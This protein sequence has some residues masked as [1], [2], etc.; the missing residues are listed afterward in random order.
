MAQGT[1]RGVPID[2]DPTLAPN[3]DILVPSQSAVRGYAVPQTRTLTING[4]TYDLSADRT[5]IIS[6]FFILESDW[7]A[8]YNYLGEAV[9]GS[10]TSASVWTIRRI[11]VSSSGATTTLSSAPNVKWTDRYTVV[12]S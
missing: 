7:V 2:T 11:Q 1:T 4:T 5:W 9:P 6:N 3:S 12:Y 10:S 8:P